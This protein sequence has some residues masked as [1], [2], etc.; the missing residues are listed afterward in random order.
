MIA[1]AIIGIAMAARAKAGSALSLR[2]IL[3]NMLIA[4]RKGAS[5]GS[6]MVRHRASTYAVF[7]LAAWLLFKSPPYVRRWA[8]RLLHSEHEPDDAL[9]GEYP[10][11]E[12]DMPAAATAALRQADEEEDLAAVENS[13]IAA[14]LG[15]NGQ[16]LLQLLLDRYLGV[17]QD[18]ALSLAQR[19]K[20]R[21]LG[22][23]EMLCAANDPADAMYIVSTGSLHVVGHASAQEIVQSRGTSTMPGPEGRDLGNAAAPAQSSPGSEHGRGTTLCVFGP[24]STLGENSLLEGPG[25]L[26]VV[27]VRAGLVGAKILELDR[28]TYEWFLEQWPSSALNFIITTTARHYRVAWWTLVNGLRLP[29]QWA[30]ASEQPAAPVL[31]GVPVA[32]P[33]SDYSSEGPAGSQAEQGQGA[34]PAGVEEQLRATAVSVL[35]CAAGE[36]LFQEGTPADCTYVL[37]RGEAEAWRGVAVT[38]SG[39]L[40]PEV[41][42]TRARSSSAEPVTEQVLLGALQPGAVAGGVAL[43]T[44]VAHQES[45]VCKTSCMW[46]SY[47]RRLFSGA[48]AAGAWSASGTELVT[49]SSERVDMLLRIGLT[50]AGSLVPMMRQFLGLGLQRVWLRAGDVLYQREDPADDMYLIIS[51]RVRLFSDTAAREKHQVHDVVRGGSLGETSVLRWRPGIAT[52]PRREYT[53]VCVR[54][55][56]LVRVTAPAFAYIAAAYPEIVRQ[57]AA[58]IAERY[59]TAARAVAK[60]AQADAALDMPAGSEGVQMGS[61]VA[62]PLF[63]E[64]ARDFSAQLP[65]TSRVPAETIKGSMSVNALVDM[66]TDMPITPDGGISLKQAFATGSL[67]HLL[68]GSGSIASFQ[69]RSSTVTVALFPAGGTPPATA[70][71]QAFAS[72]LT[73]S[74]R[75][76]G[77][78]QLVTPRSVDATLG[79]GTMARANLLFERARISAWLSALE[80]KS[81]FVVLL[82]DATATAWSR[83]VWSHADTVLLLGMAHTNPSLSNVERSIIFKQN[84]PDHAD[85]DASASGEGSSAWRGAGAGAAATRYG[86]A[87]HVRSLPRRILQMGQTGLRELG[88][89]AA[90]AALLSTHSAGSD[91]VSA[92]RRSF[93]RVEL[94]LLYPDASARPLNTRAWLRQRQVA[95]H[96]HVRTEGTHDVERVARFL[97]GA[98]VGLVLSG[99]GARG[100]AHMGVLRSLAQRGIPV[101]FVAGCSQGAFMGGAWAAFQDLDEV[102][103]AANVLVAGIGSWVQIVR[104]LTLPIMSYFSGAAFNDMLQEAF[105]NIQIEDCWIRY[106]NTVTNVTQDRTDISLTGSLWRTAR[107]SMTVLGLLPP[108]LNANKDLLI[109]GGYTDNM[110][111]YSMRKLCPAI[112]TVIAVDVENKSNEA[113]EKI[114]DYGDSLSGWTLAAKWIAATLGV[115]PPVHIPSLSLVS[116]KVSYISHTMLM[117]RLLA[118]HPGAGKGKRADLIY[119]QPDV[120]DFHLLAYDKAA[121]IV[122][123]G[124]MAAEQVLGKLEVNLQAVQ[125]Q[126]GP[127]QPGMPPAPPLLLSVRSSATPS[128]AAAGPAPSVDMAAVAQASERV[129]RPRSSPA[130]GTTV[131]RTVSFD[132]LRR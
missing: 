34:L 132:E 13:E 89:Y 68:P 101:D 122:A 65:R 66:G 74:L 78:T 40:S 28:R 38:E 96:H 44:D 93:A 94:V 58:V 25:A 39:S 2:Q 124:Y 105:G 98:A 17:S 42:A 69:R 113:M 91:R 125:A 71:L 54:D 115:G 49:P 9:E 130:R 120:Q 79:E 97:A 16:R 22:P 55:C 100:L 81:R 70:D 33:A 86:I 32:A 62:H 92:A 5:I 106:A 75:A 7:L 112:S 99:G 121:E 73:C 47:P 1:L 27:G 84:A 52:P 29:A 41:P 85:P 109:D 87:R 43:L 31:R 15:P 53:A 24:G 26:R 23:E 90:S 110:P 30:A 108:M 111:V 36:T 45:I 129:V 128:S 123:L 11:E 127:W 21:T 3:G 14:Q 4:H 20:P 82:G 107:A 80:A 116:L 56:E 61:D 64:G 57:F 104:N 102:A 83:M 63:V 117:R 114:T 103:R 95:W 119:M 8:K 88:G 60:A 6:W 46:A 131:P 35:Q 10:H 76:W 18:A 118:S 50:V 51:G 19:L 37:L 67:Q 48:A 77:K 59:D 126:L 72:A 12:A